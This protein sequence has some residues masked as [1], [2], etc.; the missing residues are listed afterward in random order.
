EMAS[1][2]RSIQRSMS[3]REKPEADDG[4]STSPGGGSP[5]QSRGLAAKSSR[6]DG[7]RHS[8]GRS[9]E[10]KASRRDSRT[11]EL[12]G[13]SLEA[14]KAMAAQA[15]KDIKDYARSRCKKKAIDEMKRKQRVEKEIARLE[16]GGANSTGSRSTSPTGLRDECDEK[17]CEEEYEKLERHYTPGDDATVEVGTSVAAPSADAGDA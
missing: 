3:T 7:R 11:L 13:L 9:L 12:Q 17:T 4:G 1:I 2:A 15:D 8:Q 10:R 14:L 5:S 16:S 6:S